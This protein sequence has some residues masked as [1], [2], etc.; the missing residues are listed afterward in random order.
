MPPVNRLFRPPADIGNLIA[1]RDVPALVRCLADPDEVTRTRAAKAL[2][3]IGP[4]AVP[5][6]LS[7]L[8][9]PRALVRLGAIEALAG[10][11]DPA[12]AR[13][14]IAHLEKE[15][16]SEF[17][18]AVVFALGEIGS[19]E[20]IPSLVRLLHNNAKYLRYAAA[21]SLD[22]L[23]WEPEDESDRIRYR[24]ARCDWDAVRN[25]GP[26]AVPLLC[27]IS[28][29]PDPAIR[30]RIVSLI[31][32]I[33]AGEGCRACEAGIRDRD[34]GVRWASVLA[35]MNCGITPSRMPFFL[36][37]RNRPGPNPLAAGILNFL[38]LGLGY[39]YI[40]KWWGFPVF[41]SYM[42]VIVLAQLATGPFFPYLVA[43]PVTA[44]LGL[45]TYYLAR[46]I[47]DRG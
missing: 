15:K 26:L 34:P 8:Q 20:A 43:Y 36:A 42:S 1:V 28:H 5:D 46:R 41:M 23:G 38:F 7:G 3:A 32:E 18:C 13:P 12:S 30:S 9:S 39:N 14:L 33:G 22:R 16:H 37:S 40:G 6:L 44:V 4:V 17:L 35:A 31:G 10:I 47:S 11:G 45:H 19:P 27:D 25:A 29:D 24:I 21:V 2:I